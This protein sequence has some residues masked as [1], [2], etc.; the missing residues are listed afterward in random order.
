[1]NRRH[2]IHTLA[3]LGSGLAAPA[4]LRG[5]HRLF[6][7]AAQDYSSR[8]I[9]L[10]ED[11][12]VVDMLNQFR[13]ADYAEKPP[14]SERFLRELGAFSKAEWE[15]YRTSGIRALA[16]G[17]GASSYEGAVKWFA[18]WNGFLAAHDEW[19]VRI[20]QAADFER[21]R[22][23]RRLGVMLTFQNSDH[24]RT[25][26]DVDVFFALGQRASQLT[27][28]FQNRLGSGFLETNDGGLTVFGAQVVER[29]NKAGMAV[30][31]SHCADRT[32]MDGIAA[33]KKPAIFTHATCRALLP[34]HLR[35]KTD[36]AI[37]AMARTG[38]VMG[39]AFI[40]FMIRLE[41]P[42]TIEHALDHFDHVRKL[43]GVEHVGLGSDMDVLGNPQP[44]NTPA[45]QAGIEAQPNFAR[46]RPHSSPDGRITIK[47]L[48]HP[49]R[50]YDVAEGL[51]RRKWSDA[52][53]RL[54]LGGNWT[55][56]LGEV[57]P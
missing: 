47:G 49:R 32:T 37:R 30:D 23:S 36:E 5:R 24:F 16:L 28:N 33:S 51:V 52:E 13:F 29:M 26:D 39:I 21:A 2:A 6:A 1:M 27:Y 53:I 41:E 46:Y 9:R 3:A 43:V 4:V 45:G 38:G 44:V 12:V 14:R 25:V 57:W 48:D 20:D 54:A 8:A 22:A 11:T 7:G 42:T 55:R 19:L 50:V 31:L 15:T 10:V 17:H 35:C 18:D 34:G 56:V 40:R